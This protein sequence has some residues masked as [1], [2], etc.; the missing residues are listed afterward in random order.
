MGMQ[1]QDEKYR[2]KELQLSPIDIHC[3]SC[4]ERVPA[5]NVNVDKTLGKCD[6]CNRLFQFGMND[7]FHEDRRGRPEFIMPEGTEVLK[8]TESLDIDIN[9]FR[10][11]NKKNL[12]GLFLFTLLWN[13]ILLPIVV[14]LV[15]SNVSLVALLPMSLHIIAG[16][17]MIYQVTRK[18]LNKTNIHVTKDAIEI[19]DG[20][21]NIPFSKNSRRFPAKD[22][23]QLYV[24]KYF[25]KVI[26]NGKKIYA[27]G[28]YA[29]L[30]SGEKVLLIKDMDRE[31]QLY[32]EQ[33]MER[34]LEIEDINVGGE[35]LE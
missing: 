25:T 19:S 1:D 12:G 23:A 16:L 15:V 3:P 10:S 6:S 18:V 35:I 24:T 30:K 22:I 7:I 26:V 27:Y 5:A 9:W 17:G 11:S 14:S 32:L 28:L 4:S 13:L 8:L 20:P 33:E 34:F 29:I 21:L 2:Y 31:T